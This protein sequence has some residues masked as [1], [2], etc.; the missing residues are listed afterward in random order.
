MNDDR[1]HY[2]GTLGREL[3]SEVN[4]CSSVLSLAVL[5]SLGLFIPNT[6]IAQDTCT[7]R[8]QLDTLYCDANNDPYSLKYCSI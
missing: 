7:N 6:A 5:A 1:K 8:G 2:C 4:A 3:M